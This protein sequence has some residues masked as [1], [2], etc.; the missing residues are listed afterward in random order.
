MVVGSWPEEIE[1]T[2]SASTWT[3]SLVGL[4]NLFQCAQTGD[5]TISFD[6][7]RSWR[8]LTLYSRLWLSWFVN[9]VAVTAHRKAMGQ[10][11]GGRFDALQANHSRVVNGVS[12]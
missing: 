6:N 12:R 9:S 11:I 4:S 7:S 8:H 5:G 10:S 2:T 3:W 1:V